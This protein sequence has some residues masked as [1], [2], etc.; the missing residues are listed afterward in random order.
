MRI[1]AAG[2]DDLAIGIDH[3]PHL[4]R[5]AERGEAARR[6]DRG[7]LVAGDADIGRLGSRGQDGKAAGHDDIEHGGS[8]VL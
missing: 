4:S 7:D 3:P 5:W 2:D 8:L 6:A 1:D